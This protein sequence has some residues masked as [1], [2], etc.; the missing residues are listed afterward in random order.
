MV[1][2]GPDVFSRRFADGLLVGGL[3]DGHGQGRG[4]AGE[5]RGVGRDEPGGLPLDEP[6]PRACMTPALASS[7][8][9]HGKPR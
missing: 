8:F 3:D 2:R 1:E 7:E 6:F 5:D 4:D 9:P